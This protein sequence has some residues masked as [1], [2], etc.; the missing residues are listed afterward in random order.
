MREPYYFS[1]NLDLKLKTKP[2]T[3]QALKDL[4][5]TGNYYTNTI[6]ADDLLNPTYLTSETDF[7]LVPFMNTLFTSD[8]S[9][10]N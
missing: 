7:N 5:L 3:T 1:D 6:N 4:S 2:L 10:E 9:Y 8:D